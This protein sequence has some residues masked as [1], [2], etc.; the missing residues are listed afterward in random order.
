M[1]MATPSVGDPAPDFTLTGTHGAFRLADQRGKTV[2]LAFYPADDTKVCTKQLCD[3]SEHWTDLAANDAVIVG[4]SA[5]DVASKEQFAAKHGLT[6]PLL[7]DPD[8]AV[9]ALYGAKAPIVGTKRSTFVI[10]GAGTI[11]FRHDVTLGLS[12]LAT[13]DLQAAIAAAEAAPA[14]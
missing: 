1:L 12:Y 14:D 2:V 13:A 8:R 4:I 7:A 10:D 11:R 6:V 5:K 3:Y 9:A